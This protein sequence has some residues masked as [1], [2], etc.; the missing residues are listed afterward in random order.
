MGRFDLANNTRP[1]ARKLKRPREPPSRLWRSAPEPSLSVHKILCTDHRSRS[2]SY[3]D[4]RNGRQNSGH[5]RT[6]G[7][8]KSRSRRWLK[9]QLGPQSVHNLGYRM[10]TSLRR[11]GSWRCQDPRSRRA[12]PACVDSQFANGGAG[13]ELTEGLDHNVARRDAVGA[14]PDNLRVR[15]AQHGRGN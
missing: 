2:S 1:D 14:G 13:H 9:H 8:D 11:L 15:A 4:L 10:M 5:T 3:N 6:A 7:G 12:G